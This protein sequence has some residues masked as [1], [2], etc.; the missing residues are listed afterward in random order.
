MARDRAI[1]LLTHAFLLDKRTVKAD[2]QSHVH[3]LLNTIH[4]HAH[5]ES[6]AHAHRIT[7][8][9]T[10]CQKLN[11]TAIEKRHCRASYLPTDYS[12]ARI[13]LLYSSRGSGSFTRKPFLHKPLLLS[14]RLSYYICTCFTHHINLGNLQ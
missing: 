7:S 10:L 6:H 2:S 3:T 13:L 12:T 1:I 11:K 9:A 4:V 5:T 8:A 14:S